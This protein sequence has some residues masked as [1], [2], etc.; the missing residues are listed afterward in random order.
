MPDNRAVIFIEASLFS[1]LVSN[2]GRNLPEA[3]KGRIRPVPA[4][5]LTVT[6]VRGVVKTGL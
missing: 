4:N 6:R 2:L 5:A 3:P 1:R